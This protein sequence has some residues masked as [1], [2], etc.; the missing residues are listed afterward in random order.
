M[1]I[2][3]G[4]PAV[5]KPSFLSAIGSHGKFLEESRVAIVLRAKEDRHT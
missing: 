5:R 1:N 4:E 3:L 2:W